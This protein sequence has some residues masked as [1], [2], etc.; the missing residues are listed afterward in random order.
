MHDLTQLD[1]RY[2]VIYYVAHISTVFQVLGPVLVRTVNF[3]DYYLV[4]TNHPIYSLGYF[5]CW[6]YS[7]G[8]TED[9]AALDFM[10]SLSEAAYISGVTQQL[11]GNW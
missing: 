8:T 11:G 10:A 3:L 2:L 4:G 6:Q 7:R 9:Q 1:D 5:V